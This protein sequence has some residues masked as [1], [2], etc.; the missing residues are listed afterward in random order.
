MAL[1]FP[2]AS[3]SYDEGAA[4]V[5]FWGHDGMMEVA[6][7]LE[8]AALDGLEP[9]LSHTESN[10]L[11]AFDTWQDRIQRVAKQVYSRQHRGVQVI[12]ASDF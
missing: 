9:R 8:V 12:V 5:R 10:I 2:N 7:V 3:R 1:A 6:F 11:K 4:R